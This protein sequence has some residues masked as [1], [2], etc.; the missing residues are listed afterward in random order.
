[1]DILSNKVEPA[2]RIAFI[3]LQP[4][5]RKNQQSKLEKHKNQSPE[6]IE[7]EITCLICM[8]IM[9]KPIC[10][11][12]CLH[13]FCEFCCLSWKNKSNECPTCRIVTIDYKKN[14][15]YEDIINAFLLKYPE[16][17]KITE[18]C[19]QCLLKIEGFMCLTH[20]NH[21]KCKQ[22]NTL[23]PERPDCNQKC[24]ICKNVYCNLYSFK[25]NSGINYLQNYFDKDMYVPSGCFNN[26][27]E[28][29]IMSDYL[30]LNKVNVLDFYK[31]GVVIEPYGIS[32]ESPVCQPCANKTLVQVIEKLRIAANSK[33]PPFIQS[34]P[35][36]P[37]GKNCLLQYSLLHI[38]KYAHV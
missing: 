37:K 20:Q 17:K 33:L 24:F 23:M 5:K 22:C 25:C 29:N 34:K 6:A 16:K 1:L 28:E 30:R 3:F 26:I 8:E 21:I 4:L 11:Y 18:K 31:T 9:I 2:S 7:D 19:E 12:P 32:L 15:I 35:K 13:T 36:C 14:Q 38:Q 27:V 10:L